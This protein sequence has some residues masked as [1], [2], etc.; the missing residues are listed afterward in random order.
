MK[1]VSPRFGRSVAA[2]QRKSRT[3]TSRGEVAAFTLVEI[4]VTLTIISFLAALSMPAIVLVKRKAIATVVGNDLRV[5]AAAIN[6]YA[7]EQGSWPAEVDAG[8]FPA[9]MAARIKEAS[10]LQ[11][12]RIGGQYNWDA[13]QMHQG[14]RYRGV[15]AISSTGT[16]ALTEDV[17]LW[18]A[19]DRAIDDG[20]L[21]SGNFRIG[22]DNEPIF[23]VAP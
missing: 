6:A 8:V 10:W 19:V 17:D 13:D 9:E 11:P 23:I 16:S 22:A 7:H 3:K 5:F 14:T 15:I 4:M 1:V 18:E 20:V 2:L 12:T 21:T